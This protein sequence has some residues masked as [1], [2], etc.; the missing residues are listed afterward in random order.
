[1][2]QEVKGYFLLLSRVGVLFWIPLTG[3]MSRIP[4]G[5]R[6]LLV[7]VLALSMYFIY[8]N[9]GLGTSY[10][11][12]GLALLSEFIFGLSTAF[13]FAL[14]IVVVLFF[15]RVVDMQLGLGAAGILNPNTSTND[16]LVGTAISITALVLFW[17]LGLHLDILHI[18]LE[19]LQIIPLGSA[20]QIDKTPL[21]TYFSSAF[22]TGLFLFFPVM[23]S[24]FAVD[25]ASG[26]VSKSMP[27]MNVYFVIMPLKIMVGLVVLALSLKQ[28]SYRFEELVVSPVNFMLSVL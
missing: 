23:A 3:P 9:K 7:N 14:P 8:L 6:L 13:V 28:L 4:M 27:Q 2:E 26:I 18:L 11:E 15:G 25:I 10:P 20:F 24:V 17:S 12:F 22:V 19:T 1:M 21:L 16:S 5:I